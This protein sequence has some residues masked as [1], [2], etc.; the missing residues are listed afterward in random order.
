MRSSGV[1]PEDHARRAYDAFAPFY[2]DFTSHH[3]DAL[4]TGVLER[5]ALR[6]GLRGR[7]LLDLACGTGR[8]FLPMLGRGYAVTACDISPAMVRSAREKSGG[9]AEVV[10]ADMREL[11]VL[12]EFDLV[13]C[14][15]DALN[16]LQDE[17]EVAALFAGVRRNLAGGGVFVCDVNTLATF[18]TVY[19]S[20]LV[21]PSAEQVLIL[22]GHGRRELAPNGAAVVWIDR[23]VPTPAGWWRR[24]RSV[25]HHRHHTPA[26][27]EHALRA[28]GLQPAGT[29]GSRMSG[30]VEPG[31]DESCHVKAV[32]IARG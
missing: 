27:L 1:A 28:A 32:V 30:D 19:S 16:Y 3:D 2:D 9:A 26:F 31:V 4:W 15:G 17:R 23:L 13:W 11:D 5:L 6:A 21:K 10:V 18:R 29:H 22:D 8:S 20:L 24:T 12:G 7:R 25:H 14:L